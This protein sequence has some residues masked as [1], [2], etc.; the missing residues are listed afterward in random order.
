MSRFPPHTAPDGSCR[1]P[2]ALRLA[3]LLTGC[4]TLTAQALLLR[5]LMVS[6]Q[7]NEISFGVALAMWLAAAGGG[8][9]LGGAVAK[10][11]QDPARAFA[12]GLIV[13]GLLTPAA[14]AAARLARLIVGIPPGELAG[15]PPLIATTA[16]SVVPLAALSGSMFAMAVATASHGRNDA[17]RAISLVYVLEAAGAVLAGLATSLVLFGHAAPLG[18]A[19][20]AATLACVGGLAVLIFGPTVRRARF[21]IAAA[22]ALAVLALT[23]AAPPVGETLDTRLAA[24]AWRGAGFVAQTQSRHGLIVAA[25][26]GSQKSMFENGVLVASVPDRLA[27]EE[28]VHLV[29]LEHPRPVSVLL[30]GGALGG[31]VEE[32]LKHPTVRRVDC[33]ELDP[34]LVGAAERAFG[35]AMTRAL[36][37]PRVSMHY[38]D[39]RFFVKRARGPYDVVIVNVPDP[40]TAQANRFYTTEFMG[41]VAAVLAQGGVAGFAVSSAEEYV[42]PELAT[43]LACVRR[44]L[45]SAF[46]HVLLVPGNPCHFIA[47][48]APGL[49]TLDAG[50]LSSRIEERA[51]DVVHVRGYY[52]TDRLSPDRIAYLEEQVTAADAPINADLSPACYYLSLVLWSQRV[53]AGSGAL[54][55]APRA[56]T[57]AHA[58]LLAAALAIALAVVS[59][60]RR[61]GLGLRAIL[62]A[63]VAVAGFTEIGIEIAALL[64]FQSVYGFVYHIVAAITGAFMGGLALGGWLGGRAALRGAG[65]GTVLGI[66]AALAAAPA[67]VGWVAGRIAALPPERAALGVAL[68]PLLV[69]GSAMLSGALFPIAARLLSRSG[70]AVESGG[71]AY[72]ADLLGAAVGALVAGV[73]L[74]PVMGVRSTMLV[75][76]MLNAAVAV[77]VTVALVANA[78]GGRTAAG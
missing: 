33:V 34:A 58:G 74:L 51:L 9:V 71:R 32:V 16:L 7:G 43:L 73:A 62:L 45:G 52:L 47:S 64:V 25:E 8:S 22:A 46:T 14:V 65:I 26:R 13:L 36:R 50:V 55:A 31:A 24:L 60:R 54:L 69:I 78:R 30:L 72:G 56:L 35:E 5:E 37:D 19:V 76:S 67:T 27:A 49:L 75:L 41:E 17:G 12:W 63:A 53:S 66:T 18:I 38:A 1:R 39:A 20:L 28:A 68:I 4:T 48:D 77:A 61:S 11:T 57:L 15:L 70:G 6:W 2:A 44:S 40:T 42:G 59:A 21:E 23:A 29:M 10:R 3:F